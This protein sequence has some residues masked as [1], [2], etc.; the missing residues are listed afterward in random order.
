MGGR[1]QAST[2]YLPPLLAREGGRERPVW[3]LDLSLAM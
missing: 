3:S 2:S 1:Q